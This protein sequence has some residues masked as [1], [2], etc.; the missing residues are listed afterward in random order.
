MAKFIYFFLAALAV[1]A[2]VARPKKTPPTEKTG[3][4]QFMENV[5]TVRKDIEA[6]IKKVLPG[7]KDIDKALVD[8]SKA[9]ATTVEK[10]TRDL[11][12]QADK[13]KPVIEKLVKEASER[14]SESVAYIKGLVGEDTVKKGEEVRKHVETNI[15]NIFAEG[16]KVEEALMPSLE[17]AQE[18]MKKVAEDFFGML[19]SAGERLKADLDKAIAEQAPKH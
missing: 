1:Q 13:N 12:E 10:G 14:I 11:T 8:V 5:D 19:K 3:L 18:G 4:E 7:N 15:N 2:V 6:T 17:H 9:F 16:K